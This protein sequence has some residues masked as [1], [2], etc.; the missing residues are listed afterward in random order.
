MNIFTFISDNFLEVFSYKAV[1]PLLAKDIVM[2][3][4]AKEGMLELY[5]KV[6]LPTVYTLYDMEK[7]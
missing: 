1:V 4:L 2:D 3:K 7:R 5:N 6:E